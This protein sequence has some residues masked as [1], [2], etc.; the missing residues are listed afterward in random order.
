MYFSIFDVWLDNESDT[1]RLYVYIHILLQYI[2]YLSVSWILEWP[3]LI[4]L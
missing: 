1:K 2:D 4:G 3:F